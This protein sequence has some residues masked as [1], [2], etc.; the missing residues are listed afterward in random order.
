MANA[1][2]FL[3]GLKDIDQYIRL[4]HLREKEELESLCTQFFAAL[5]HHDYNHPIFENTYPD[6]VSEKLQDS[7]IRAIDGLPKCDGLRR[8][9]ADVLASHQLLW[10]QFPEFRM[11]VDELSIFVDEKFSL[12]DVLVLFSTHG[13]PVGR[14][15][16]GG[17][18]VLRWLKDGRT[19]EW[20]VK[21]GMHMQG[22]MEFSV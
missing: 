20:V 9:L 8:G 1:R 21:D 16:K 14:N 12:A 6:A 10:Q 22:S 7:E 13:L 3:Y 4:K 5:D 17:L 18:C 15:G 11:T 19:S 2:P